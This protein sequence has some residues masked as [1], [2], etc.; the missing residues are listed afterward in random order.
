MFAVQPWSLFTVPVQSM[1]VVH[2]VAIVQMLRTVA[3]L[4]YTS[5][6]CAH[7]PFEVAVK[8]PFIADPSPV[9]RAAGAGL[10]IAISTTEAV[11][12][13]AMPP[14]EPIVAPHW[15]ANR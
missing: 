5:L 13:L 9:L 11:V 12:A 3:S 1:G 10:K 14:N 15:V 8:V 6:D 7:S 2:V 4:W